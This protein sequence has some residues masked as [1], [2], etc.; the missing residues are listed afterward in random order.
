MC[1]VCGV[2]TICGGGA[3]VGVVCVCVMSAV[4]GGIG[5]RFVPI[6]MSRSVSLFIWEEICPK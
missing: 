4:S 2:C 1:V 5:Q 3:C 6:S